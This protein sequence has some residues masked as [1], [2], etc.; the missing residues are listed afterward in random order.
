VQVLVLDNI[1]FLRLVT[2]LLYVYFIIKLPA[3]Y[4]TEK[5]TF[6]S[7]LIGL[8][9][10]MLTNTPGM[11]AAASVLA[12]F[13]RNYII[14]ALMGEELPGNIYPSY[15]SFGYGGFI[16]YTLS[17]VTVHHLTLFLVEAFTL[18]DALYFMLRLA[19]SIALSS[20]LIC[21]I[22]SFNTESRK[23]VD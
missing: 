8:S 21:I 16:R 1:H 2:P 23:N 14:K 5:V 19:G 6:F 13:S 4:S 10:D 12:G 22:E 9:V 7:F 3:E 20:L 18:F 15:R 11:N 17:V